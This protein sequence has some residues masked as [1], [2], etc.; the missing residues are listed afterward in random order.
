MKI[1]VVE[2]ETCVQEV[3]RT[4]MKMMTMKVGEIKEEVLL[5]MMMTMI[6]KAIQEEV[7]VA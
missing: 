7:L 1:M 4:M 3:T 5:I 6:W 2:A